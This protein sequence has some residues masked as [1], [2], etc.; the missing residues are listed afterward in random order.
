MIPSAG[1]FVGNRHTHTLLGEVQICATVL[2][3]SLTISIKIPIKNA[4]TS[5]LSIPYARY[6]TSG[7][8]HKRSPRY[9]Y[10]TMLTVASMVI[11]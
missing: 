11:V 4:Y 10:I 2:K 1:G 3:G 9:L 8:S 5:C 6:I 7:Y